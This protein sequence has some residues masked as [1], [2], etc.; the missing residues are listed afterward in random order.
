MELQAWGRLQLSCIFGGWPVSLGKS[1][2]ATPMRS[3]LGPFAFFDIAVNWPTEDP[4]IYFIQVDGVSSLWGEG[5]LNFRTDESVSSA[6]RF[7]AGCDPSPEW[8]P[9][10]C[11]NGRVVENGALDF[12]VQPFY[13]QT[14][15][16]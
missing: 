9:V 4:T 12:L 3:T 6:R 8:V 14:E 10:I 7:R 5:S 2:W 11:S 15:T 13:F 1:R 16:V